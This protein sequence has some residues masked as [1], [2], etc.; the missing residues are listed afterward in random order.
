MYLLYV[1]VISWCRATQWRRGKSVQ[2]RAVRMIYLRRLVRKSLVV[3]STA[4]VYACDIARLEK[5][6]LVYS[7]HTDPDNI[8]KSWLLVPSV[9]CYVKTLCLAN[10]GGSLWRSFHSESYLDEVLFPELPEVRVNCSWRLNPS[11]ENSTMWCIGRVQLLIDARIHAWQ[12]KSTW[13]SLECS[14]KNC[15]LTRYAYVDRP[16][17]A[18]L[19]LS[20]SSLVSMTS[21]SGACEQ[22][23]SQLCRRYI[24]Q[25]ARS[26]S[27]SE[28]RSTFPR[29]DV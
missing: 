16:C 4:P 11:Y 8:A 14:S 28:N 3:D 9:L 29:N 20:R 6:L 23:G 22:W 17:R 10:S 26:I 25:T 27:T 7:E 2:G 5:R 12:V 15:T 13:Q 24:L 19:Y 21:N 1:F 18:L